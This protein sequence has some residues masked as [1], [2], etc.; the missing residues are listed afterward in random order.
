MA[1]IDDLIAQISEPRAGEQLKREWTEMRKTRQF[2]LVFD[3]HL[4]ELVPLPKVT[5][6]RG[7]T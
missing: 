7:D 3:G 6:K 5:P 2:G 1:S 4:P